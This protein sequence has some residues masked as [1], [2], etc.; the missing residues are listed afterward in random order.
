[1]EPSRA[2][3]AS[4]AKNNVCIVE[5]PAVKFELTRLVTLWL[6]VNEAITNSL[7]HGFD[8]REAGTISIKLEREGEGYV[9]AIGRVVGN[10]MMSASMRWYRGEAYGR[11]RPARTQT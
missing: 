8:S 11:W 10:Q 7:K 4:G 9:L 1:L 5:V 2:S 3:I 6:L